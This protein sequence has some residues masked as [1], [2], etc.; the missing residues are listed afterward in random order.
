MP[1][2][3]EGDF[4]LSLPGF[5]AALNECVGIQLC[6]SLSFPSAGFDGLA[7]EPAAWRDIKLKY[8]RLSSRSQK[9]SKFVFHLSAGSDS[10]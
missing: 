9:E 5:G 8:L 3:S 7:D 4:Q 10:S 6:F 1:K 2:A